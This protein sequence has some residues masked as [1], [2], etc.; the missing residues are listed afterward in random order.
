MT[1]TLDTAGQALCDALLH[2]RRHHQPLAVDDRW[3]AAVPDE[4]AAWSLQQ[5]QGVALGA[6]GPHEVP[7]FWKCGAAHRQAPLGH[8]PLLPGGVF[9]A[10]AD[11]SGLP[12]FQ[13]LVE[14]EIALRLA[15]AVHPHEAAR[16]TPERAEALIDAMAVAIEVV[17]T[18]WASLS[19]APALCKLADFQ[20]HGALVLGPWQPWR[21]VD[22]A[23]QAGSLQVAGEPPVAFQGSH[24]LG[25]PP[26]L[27]P[28][29][30]RHLCRHGATVPAGTVVTTGAWCGAL[31]LLPGQRACARFD[32]LGEVTL[33][34]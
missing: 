23:A 29:W 19:Q 27:L 14:A 31:P 18:R 3:H 26:W 4:A 2:A 12:L 21:C 32:G 15:Q 7:R 28:A 34:R 5:A 1:D 33:Q 25:T 6:W 22:W 9:D 10:P 30:L 8:A 20:V 13:P 24:P 16:L 11:L 17:D